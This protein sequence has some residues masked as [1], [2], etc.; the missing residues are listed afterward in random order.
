MV[1]TTL[2]HNRPKYLGLRAIL[3]EI[4]LPLSGWVSILHRLSGALLFLSTV[5]L[6]F[7]L[8]R[9]LDSSY[10]FDSVKR[11]LSVPA[12]RFALLLLIWAYCHHFCA[13]I[14]YLFLDL[15]KGVERAAAQFTSGVVVAVSLLLTTWL[16][17]KLW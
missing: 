17:M 9:S 6:L 2:T 1:N 4:R 5:W 13:G 8:D 10:S 3:F 14:R 16:G 11:E 15:G 7:M 12:V